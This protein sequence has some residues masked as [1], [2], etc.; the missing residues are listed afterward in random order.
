MASL[1]IE[2]EEADDLATRRAALRGIFKATAVKRALQQE[3][4]REEQVVP[5]REHMAAWRKRHPLGEA[6]VGIGRDE[7]REAI[8]AHDRYGLGRHRARLNMG[9][10]VAYAC[11]KTND[12]RLLYKG[13]DFSHT[14]L[15]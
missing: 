9:D 6:T 3:L 5:P 12:A 4:A 15:A 7:Y 10:C 14:D 13:V 8:V 1:H 11:A 2:D